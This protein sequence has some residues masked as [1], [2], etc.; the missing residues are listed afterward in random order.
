MF[1]YN[2]FLNVFL[3]FDHTLFPN[4]GELR[5]I[6]YSHRRGVRMFVEYKENLIFE[7]VLIFRNLH[8]SNQYVWYAR[9]TTLSHV[10]CY[11]EFGINVEING[12][13]I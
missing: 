8:S 10:W 12:K 4:T 2:K 6:R 13:K 7:G 1:D 11:V 9:V 5:V 3:L